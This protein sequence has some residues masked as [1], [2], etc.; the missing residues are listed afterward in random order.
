[1]D[2]NDDLESKLIK[3]QQAVN[4]QVNGQLEN[5]KKIYLQ[6]DSA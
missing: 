2:E 4:L 6:L 5:A 1:M 3:L